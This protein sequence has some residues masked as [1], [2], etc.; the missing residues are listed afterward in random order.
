MFIIPSRLFNAMQILSL[1]FMSKAHGE[2]PRDIYKLMRAMTRIANLLLSILC[3]L[4][5]LVS[6]GTEHYRVN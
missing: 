1:T 2:Q 4:F 3:S 6:E 5:L